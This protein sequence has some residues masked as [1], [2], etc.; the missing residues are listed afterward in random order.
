MKDKILTIAVPSFNTEE[1]MEKNILTMMCSTVLEDIEILIINDGSKDSTKDKAEKLY[2]EYPETI[3]VVNKENGGHGSVINRGIIEATGKYFKV[4]DGDD[5]VDSDQFDR[6][7]KMLHSLDVDC[8]LND[9]NTVSVVT[10]NVTRISPIQNEKHINYERIYNFE[11]ALRDLYI[12]IHS[13]TYKT[14]ILKN[15][16]E[17]IKFTEK[18]FY[19]DLEYVTYPIMYMSSVYVSEFNV[20]QYLIDQ[21]SQSVSNESHKKNIAH[22]IIGIRNM[23]KKYEMVKKELSEQKKLYFKEMI[24]NRI[25]GVYKIYLTFNEECKARWLEL[26]RFDEELLSI[27]KEIYEYSYSKRVVKVLRQKS[28]FWFRLV[29]IVKG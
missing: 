20:Y 24:A 16:F 19:E 26:K 28:Y 2:R 12:T 11:D 7:V 13:V 25:V 5:Y 17:D 29:S 23:S 15:H 3:R 27:S 21:K 1:F 10:G 4:I 9:F 6:F 22:S 14:A 18:V 8:I